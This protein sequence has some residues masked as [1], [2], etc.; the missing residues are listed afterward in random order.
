MTDRDDMADEPDADG[1]LTILERDDLNTLDAK[2]V[3]KKH[4]HAKK[5]L[6]DMA[7]ASVLVGAALFLPVGETGLAIAGLLFIVPF[8]RLL[9]TYYYGWRAVGAPSVYKEMTEAEAD[10]KYG[11]GEWGP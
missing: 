10:R 5:A 3:Y 11:E 8:A 1:T 9:A 4:A 7:L 2:R 6:R